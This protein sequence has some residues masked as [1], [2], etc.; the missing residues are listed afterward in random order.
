MDWDDFQARARRVIPLQELKPKR[1]WIGVLSHEKTPREDLEET[2]FVWMI[3]H[4]VSTCPQYFSI[5]A[6][7]LL[8]PNPVAAANPSLY[9]Q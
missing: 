6:K 1:C 5:L 8:F 9:W 7:L 4:I 3:G 2:D